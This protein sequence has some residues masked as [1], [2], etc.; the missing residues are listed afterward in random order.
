MT[1]P[2]WQAPTSGQAPLAAHVNQLLCGHTIVNLYTGTQT[3]AVTTNGTA[4][5]NSNSL[6]M[7]QSFTTA[8]G[9]TAIGYISAPIGSYNASGSTLGTMTINLYANSAGTPTGSPIV[10]TTITTEYVQKI[11]SG[12]DTVYVSYPLPATG[13]SP[14]TT[15]WIVT[16]PAGDGANHY[17]WRQSASVSGASTSTNGTTWTAQSY[18]L[19]YQVFDQTASGNKVHSWE[20]G[21]ARWTYTAYNN[22]GTISYYAEYTVG[23]T[24]AGY[25]QSSRSLS[26][27]SALLTAVQ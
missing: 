12:V 24:A 14:S 2:I 18:G 19:Q 5:T 6:Y 26:Y 21:G 20:D 9:Q 17:T 1:T 11:T 25:V 23:Q 7:A 13:L 27:T 16:T 4:H 15:Y 10:T 8:A 3:S 22:S